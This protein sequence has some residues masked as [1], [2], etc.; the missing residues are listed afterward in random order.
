MATSSPVNID[1]ALRKRLHADASA[2]PE[3]WSF[4][5]DAARRH[6]HA[7]FQYPAMMVPQMQARFI[8][9]VCDV[10]RNVRSVYDPFVGSGT[11]LTETMLHGLD[12]FGQDVNPL[13]ILLC[14]V[15]AGPFF[16]K[17]L[18]NRA[19]GIRDH[20]KR[21]RCRRTEA[22]FS[23]L[24]KWFRPDV[25]RDLSKIVRA[26][27]TE[28]ELWSRRFFWVCLAEAVR[29]TSNSR[30]STVKLHIRPKREI[31]GRTLDAIELFH[32]LVATN[33]SN[34]SSKYELLEQKAHAAKGRYKGAVRTRLGDSASSE[35][36]RC[37]FDLLITSPPYG[38]NVTTVTYGQHAYLPLQWID[39]RDIDEDFDDALLGSTHAIDSQSLGGSRK[40][41]L[42]VI[43][44]LRE[45]S[46]AFGKTINSLKREPRD[47][48]LRVAA[49]VRDLDACLPSIL[50]RM[51]R[52]AY[53]IW[54]VGNRCVGGQ[55]VPLRDILL[56]LLETRG[57]IHVE[58]LDRRIPSKRMALHNGIAATMTNETVLVTRKDVA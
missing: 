9:D 7:M 57:A 53:M 22:D 39:R 6:A 30:T 43:P 35:A 32:R 29:L 10:S 33:V 11:V 55:E 31:N 50:N 18:A 12:F 26:I 1:D 2:N 24:S 40:R 20:I 41:A 56:E 52:N 16:T 36:D 47:R 3:Y 23:G 48:H 13:A 17:S 51:R 54:V 45:R 8:D 14:R 27:R 46:A 38:D 4:R 19:A 5:F 21:D 25:A 15:K 28:R 34:L 37:R 42:E 44:D 49:F 58:T